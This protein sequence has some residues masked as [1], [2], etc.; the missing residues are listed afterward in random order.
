MTSSIPDAIS[1]DELLRIQVNA[2]PDFVPAEPSVE[3]PLYDGLTATEVQELAME[4]LRGM[5]RKCKDP[6]VEKCMMLAMAASWIRWHTE[7]AQQVMP[8]TSDSEKGEEATEFAT[9]C[10]RDAGKAQAIYT[11]VHDIGMDNDFILGIDQDS[12]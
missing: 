2:E 1:T 12:E 7:M 9:C 6:M 4:T 8:S 5:S 11:L 3:K 10:L